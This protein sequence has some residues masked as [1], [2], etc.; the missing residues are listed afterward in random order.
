MH[1]KNMVKIVFNNNSYKSATKARTA[2]ESVLREHAKKNRNDQGSNEVPITSSAHIRMCAEALFK[3]HTHFKEIMKGCKIEKMFVRRSQP[4]TL[5]VQAS[6]GYFR[7]FHV[8]H[9]FAQPKKESSVR[10]NRS[11]RDMCMFDEVKSDFISHWTYT[12]GGTCATCGTE[13]ATHVAYAD[14]VTFE[15]LV[16]KFDTAQLRS[17][18]EKISIRSIINEK[19]VRKKKNVTP[20]NESH[21]RTQKEAFL[22]ETYGTWVCDDNNARQDWLDFHAIEATYTF[23][24][25]QCAEKK[26]IFSTV[27]AEGKKSQSF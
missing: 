20:V 13:S 7:I 18:A 24:C 1:K 12:N 27:H 5:F 23:C 26:P 9:F 14:G 15:A 3:H 22:R 21:F 8:K 11:V 19:C 17:G 2:F 16:D 6:D 10:I 4:G 25:S